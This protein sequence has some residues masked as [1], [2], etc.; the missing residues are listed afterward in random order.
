MEILTLIEARNR[1]GRSVLLQLPTNPDLSDGLG[2]IGQLKSVV[3][4]PVVRGLP[5]RLMVSDQTQTCLIRLGDQFRVEPT[6][7][8]L[9]NLLTRLSADR[10][11]I[12]YDN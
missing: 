4:E 11:E 7:D 2:L 12:E 6:D 10:C 1:H 3:K 5:I 9:T 8:A